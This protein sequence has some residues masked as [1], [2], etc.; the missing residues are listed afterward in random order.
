MT[1]IVFDS[2]APIKLIQSNLFYYLKFNKF[3]VLQVF[4]VIKACYFQIPL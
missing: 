2:V 3:L 1:E 4:G